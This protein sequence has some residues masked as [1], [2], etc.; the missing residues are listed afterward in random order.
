MS[1]SHIDPTLPLIR[2][3]AV[4]ALEAQYPDL[5]TAQRQI[6]SSLDD[7]YR[8]KYAG[9][10]Q[11]QK[12]ALETSIGEVKNIYLRNVFP[13]MKVTWGTYV[14]NIGHMN[15][16]GCFRCHD[17]SHVSKDGKQIT[18]DCSACH[19][20]LAVQEQNPQILGQLQV[21]SPGSR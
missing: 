18:Q 7:F 17:G 10:Y 2:K 15:S 1:E 9:V 8:T 4:E 12:R 16:A 19:A 21:R 11:K 3:K 5:E 14:N 20:L 6:A 13:D